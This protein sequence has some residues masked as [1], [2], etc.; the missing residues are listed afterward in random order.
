M[1]ADAISQ[2]LDYLPLYLSSHLLLTLLALLIGILICLP[3]GCI[4]TRIKSLQWPV[5]TAAGILQTVPGIALL[6]LMV[7]LL[8]TIGFLPALVALVI[9][10]FLPILRN[11]ATGIM[12]IDPAIREAAIGIGMTDLQLLFKVELPLSLPIIIA[13]IRTAAVWVVG[14]A[15]LATPVGA[16]SLGNYIFSGL[17]TQNLAAVVTGCIAAAGL[18]IILDQLIRLVEISTMKRNLPLGLTATA[19]IL[20]LFAGG[21]TSRT[22]TGATEVNGRVVVGSKPFTE[23]YILAELITHQLEEAD[24]RADK[25]S[26]MG[27]L[28]LYEALA[29]SDIDCYVDYT[30]TIWTNV[31]KR[32]DIVSRQQMLSDITSWLVENHQITCLGALGFE[33]TYALAVRRKTAVKYDLKSIADLS[34]TAAKLTIGSDYEF[35]SRPE[36]QALKE[37]YGLGFQEQRTF[38]PSLMYPAIARGDVDV[39]SAY[40]TDG[41]IVDFDLVVLEDPL[42]ALPPYDAVLLLS[43]E[44]ARDTVLRSALS[45]LTK[46][47]SDNEMRFANKL[48]DVDGLPIDSAARYLKAMT[49]NR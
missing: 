47:I 33:N 19:I 17:Q 11:T 7:P 34:G 16:T 29:Q 49:G 24:Y 40:S 14:T 41:R 43:P 12:G 44:A 30:G 5:L 21:L 32:S 35:F 46:Q 42:Q 3:L 20:L 31:M 26:G 27:S 25:R 36:W 48:V 45:E 22:F 38:D 9:Y 10:S 39:I 2:Q 28:I 1:T 23:Q 15:T 37:T 13:G 6:A 18:A 4:V 8:G